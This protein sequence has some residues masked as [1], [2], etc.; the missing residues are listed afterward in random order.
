MHGGPGQSTAHPPHVLVIDD[1]PALRTTLQRVLVDAGLSVDLAANGREGLE[2]LA[3]RRPSL[4]LCDLTMPELDGLGF[5][6]ACR[7]QPDVAAVPIII[8]SSDQALA[9]ARRHLSDSGVVLLLAKP[10]DLE[11]LLGIIR[12]LVERSAA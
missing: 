6:A 9:A 10:F 5:V 7:A 2:R 1:E 3:A 12:Q 11:V 4:I 8:M